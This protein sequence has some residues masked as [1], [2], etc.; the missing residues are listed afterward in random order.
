MTR[1]NTG[2]DVGNDDDDDDDDDGG[3]GGGDDDV[4]INGQGHT[5]ELR[6]KYDTFPTPPSGGVEIADDEGGKGLGSTILPPSPP[7][8]NM[9]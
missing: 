3:G 1:P 9:G 6:E 4:T 7:S 5:V 8:L 2:C